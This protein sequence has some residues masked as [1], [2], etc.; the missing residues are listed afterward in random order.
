MNKPMTKHNQQSDTKTGNE[1]GLFRITAKAAVIG[2][3]G[4]VIVLTRATKDKRGPGNHD[5]PGGHV[6]PGETPE[7]TIR[8]EVREETG[9]AVRDI[10]PLPTYAVFTGEDGSSIQKLRFI[11]FTDGTE[12]TTDPEE[13][14][15]HEWLTLDEAIAKLSDEGYEADK[16]DTII[17]AKDYLAEKDA[18]GGWKRCL[19]DFENY[20]RRQEASQKEMGKFLVERLLNDL[21]PVLDNFRA[22]ASHVPEASKS[23]PWVTG[24]GY[25]EKQLEDVLAQHGVRVIEVGEGEPFDP[26]RHEAL[27]DESTEEDA[28]DNGEPKTQTVV[29]VLQN[30][31]MIGDKVVRAAKVTVK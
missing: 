22:A 28:E 9:L 11:A 29:K 24:I 2:P 7:D 15:A 16:R 20:K 10:V 13:H 3:D 8:R 26:N 18:L 27:S 30:G 17:Q 31:Y 21:A 25:I 1:E 14:S 23:D 12:V 4:K 6:D 19:A 5:L